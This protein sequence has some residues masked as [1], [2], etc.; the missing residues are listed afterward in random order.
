MIRSQ[1]DGTQVVNVLGELRRWRHHHRSRIVFRVG[2]GTA[3]RGELDEGLLRG[4]FILFGHDAGSVVVVDG[5][6]C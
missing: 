1:H 5:V 2:G 4:G 3:G 6:G